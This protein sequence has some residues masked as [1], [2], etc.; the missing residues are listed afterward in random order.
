L[1]AIAGEGDIQQLQEAI[2]AA[3]QGDTDKA[4]QL[5]KQIEELE[6]SSIERAAKAAFERGKIAEDNID[7]GKAYGHFERAVG[8]SPENPEYLKYAGNMAGIVARHR[9][10]T[11]WNTKALALYLKQQGEDSPDVALLRNN[12]GT[13]WQALGE[14]DKA[15]KY[16]E[17]ALARGLKTFGEDHPKVALR[18]NNLG[19]AWDSLGE[20]D[21]AIEYYELALATFENLLGV[22]HPSTKEV[23]NNLALARDLR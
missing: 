9:K 11:E 21:K 5:F 23:A 16:Y 18:R 19:S 10:K 1:R 15:I 7:Y 22:D 6:K 4:D 20:Y 12:L 3:E 13:V 2:S 14:Y 17:L 8:L